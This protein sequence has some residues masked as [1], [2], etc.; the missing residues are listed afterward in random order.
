ML[1]KK[2]YLFNFTLKI[3]GILVRND[4]VESFKG[5]RGGFKLKKYNINFYE[6]IKLIQKDIFISL[7]KKSEVEVFIHIVQENLKSML[8]NKII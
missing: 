1:I 3:L 2:R 6:I 7:E 8:E 4:F 5:I